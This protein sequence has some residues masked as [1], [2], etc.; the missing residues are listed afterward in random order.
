MVYTGKDWDGVTDAPLHVVRCRACGF[1]YLNPRPGPGMIGKFY[2]D[3]YNPYQ[4]GRGEIERSS[5]LSTTLR[6]LIMRRAYGSPAVQPRGMA[7]AFASVASCVKS[8]E[9][10][11]FGL[12]WQG[13]GRLLDFGCGAGT[14]LRRMRAMGWDVTGMDFSETAVRAVT[15]SGIRAVFG[16]LPH[17]ELSPASFDVVTMRQALEHVPDPKQTLFESRKLLAPGGML[18]VQV[19]NF[20]SWEVEHFGEASVVLDLPRHFNHFTPDTLATM[21]RGCGFTTVDVRQVARSSWIRKSAKR[22]DRRPPRKGDGLLRSKVWC[23]YV[24]N[25]ALRNGRGNELVATA[26]V[27]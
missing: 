6:T 15:D 7:R 4:S 13:Q 26:R 5:K 12:A 14:F 2:P 19:P 17:A 8:A 9:R 1:H 22:L 3:T 20:A 27:P 25:R 24:A 23:N 16:T 10:C 21:L 11:G 18:V